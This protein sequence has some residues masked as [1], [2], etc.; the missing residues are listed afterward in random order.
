MTQY[1]FSDTTIAVN[2]LFFCKNVPLN[3]TITLTH[4]MKLIF[5]SSYQRCFV[6]KNV[7][8][9]FVNLS[10]KHL[11]WS[12]FLIKLQALRP[13]NLFKRL[14]HRCFPG[15]FVKF[16][17]T[18]MLKNICQRLLLGFFFI[19]PENFRKTF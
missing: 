16:L 17:R 5:R 18:F 8:K 6:K 15:K 9:N 11:C 3:K 19:S 10:E 1:L 12:L 13:R 2:K 4:L 14:Q 7:L